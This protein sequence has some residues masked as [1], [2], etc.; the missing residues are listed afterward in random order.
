MFTQVSQGYYYYYYYYYYYH[1]Y[2]LYS[3]A[4]GEEN[5]T[6]LICI[7]IHRINKISQ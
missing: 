2:H 5:D 4:K 3:H 6:G 1:Y 7:G